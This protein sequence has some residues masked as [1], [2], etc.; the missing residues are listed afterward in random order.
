MSRWTM[1]SMHSGFHL[2]LLKGC[3]FS[4]QKG[5]CVRACTRVCVCVRACV[6]LCVCMC[7]CGCMCVV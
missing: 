4:A 7:V 1:V 3:S 6:H 5:M 2:S